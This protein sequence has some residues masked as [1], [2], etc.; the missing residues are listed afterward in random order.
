MY[1][2]SAI[3]GLGPARHVAAGRRVI[4]LPHPASR[5]PIATVRRPPAGRGTL[6]GDRID[7]LTATRV[8]N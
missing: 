3:Q 4:L 8:D 6:P 2:V 1:Q 7:E 5:Y